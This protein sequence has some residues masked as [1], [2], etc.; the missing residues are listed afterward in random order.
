M[1]AGRENVACS[2]AHALHVSPA[3]KRERKK[4][5]KTMAVV[6]DREAE[7]DYALQEKVSERA[8]LRTELSSMTLQ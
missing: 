6:A 2:P 3:A 5:N 7:R 1:D 4:R 8:A